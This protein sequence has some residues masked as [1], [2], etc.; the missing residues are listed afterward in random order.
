MEK[1]LLNQS[2]AAID[3][4]APVHD[5]ADPNCPIDSDEEKD[6]VMA[7]IARSQPIPLATHPLISTRKKYHLVRM[8]GMLS[9]ALGGTRGAGLFSFNG[10][11]GT[12]FGTANPFQT[13]S[14]AAG[15]SGPVGVA[16]G[17]DNQALPSPDAMRRPSFQ[18]SSVNNHPQMSTTVAMKKAVPTNNSMT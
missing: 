4:N 8:K 9:Q 17:M 13:D 11:A 1:D 10:E 12:M 6:A 5:D 15:F 16:D 14:P 2:E 18:N 3:A 7:G